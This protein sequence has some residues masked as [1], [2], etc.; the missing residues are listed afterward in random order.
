L[1]FFNNG[2]VIQDLNRERFDF[3][4]YINSSITDINNLKA[5]QGIGRYMSWPLDFEEDNLSKQLTDEIN[6]LSRTKYP[7][8]TKSLNIG[9]VIDRNLCKQ[10]IKHCGKKGIRI[11]ILFCYTQIKTPI[12]HSALSGLKPLGYDYAQGLSF[13]SSIPIDLLV[14]PAKDYLD[15]PVYQALI[16]CK[17]KLNTN[18][19]FENENDIV[20]YIKRR[21]VIIDSDIMW[22]EET[23]NGKT[24]SAH[25]VD[26]ET[27]LIFRLSAVTGD[28]E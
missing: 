5:Y 16:K 24:Y 1:T 27:L 9:T 8:G 7:D 4:Q 20:E 13:Y 28:L 15:Y 21:N 11:R 25:L 23:I 14:S 17:D 19:L 10:Y 2:I 26:E 12:W 3:T 6:K 18:K 22:S